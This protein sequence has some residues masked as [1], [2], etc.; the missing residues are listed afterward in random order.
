MRQ[1]Q[2]YE[3][4]FPAKVLENLFDK[5]IR[6]IL[7]KGL[8]VVS[9]EDIAAE[10][11]VNLTL[12]QEAFPKK[13]QILRAIVHWYYIKFG[14][15][16]CSD[17]AMHSDIYAAIRTTLIEFAQ[18]CFDRSREGLGLFRPTVVDL[19][20]LD[21]TLWEEFLRYNHVWEEVVHEKLLQCQLELKNPEDIEV[22]SD[23]FQM[24][25]VGLYELIKLNTSEKSIYKM[26]DLS[27]E[28]LR[29]RM[30]YPPEVVE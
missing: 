16:M 3:E 9:V 6:L 20:Y 18:L 10:S 29:S 1:V 7:Q 4:L 5:S 30:K 27:L 11:G 2:K 25:F 22:L 24:T 15:Q 12:L 23:Y 8:K 21:E 14:Q 13:Q 26:I 17:M 28:V 19:C